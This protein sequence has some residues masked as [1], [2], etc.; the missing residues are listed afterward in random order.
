MISRY[1][2]FLSAMYSA[3]QENENFGSS[4]SEKS[5]NLTEVVC[6]EK[7]MYV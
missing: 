6:N 5:A 1:E 2:D 4:V 3:V 7:T